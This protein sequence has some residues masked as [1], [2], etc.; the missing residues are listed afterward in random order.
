ML[1][2]W[3]FEKFLFIYVFTFGCVLLAWGFLNARTAVLSK[4]WP[5]VPGVIQT[6]T[7]SHQV[8]YTD[9]VEHSYSPVLSYDFQLNGRS[10]S[11]TRIA[12]VSPSSSSTG[13]SGCLEIL[14]PYP[15][16][17]SVMVYYN[18]RDPSECLLVPGLHLSNLALPL[19]G[20]FVMAFAWVI[21]MIRRAT[22]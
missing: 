6:S 16:G 4:S 10:Y 22:G 21:G 2:M 20:I 3:R 1:M 19:V 8:S 15:A 9:G 5:S 18:P 12:S 17:S 11:G 7:V 13:E 14:Q